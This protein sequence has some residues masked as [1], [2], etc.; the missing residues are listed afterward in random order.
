MNIEAAAAAAVHKR[1]RVQI[2][3]AATSRLGAL[4]LKPRKAKPLPVPEE[5]R[6]INV[7]SILQWIDSVEKGDRSNVT[8]LHRLHAT[9]G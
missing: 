9:T 3:D 5:D 6:S 1:S 4:G 8:L 2:H 7:R